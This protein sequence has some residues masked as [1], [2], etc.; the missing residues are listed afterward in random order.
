MLSVISYHQFIET[1]Y[2]VIKKHF[3]MTARQD[4]NYSSNIHDSLG[5]YFILYF[6]VSIKFIMQYKVS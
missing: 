2:T 4:Y 3:T 1:S 5:N 6:E